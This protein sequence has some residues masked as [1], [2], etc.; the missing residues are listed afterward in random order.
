MVTGDNLDT[1]R[2][3]ALDAGIVTAEEADQEYVCMDGKTFRE[4]CGG[5]KKLE[6]PN[7]RGFLKEEIGN[8]N[9]FR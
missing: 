3:I 8:K 9:T 1:A 5:L 4:T 2:A 7:N 6:D